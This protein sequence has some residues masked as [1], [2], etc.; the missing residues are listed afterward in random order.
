MFQVFRS[1]QKIKEL[2]MSPCDTAHLV[3]IGN[4]FRNINNKHVEKCFLLGHN[5]HLQALTTFGGTSNPNEMSAMDVLRREGR[6]E[7][8][9]VFKN[10][11]ERNWDNCLF[12]MKR[13]CIK[14]NDDSD[15]K[16][17]YSFVMD[18]G[19]IES[20][21]VYNILFKYEVCL[22]DAIEPEDDDNDFLVAIPIENKFDE[23]RKFYVRDI[24]HD[25]YHVRDVTLPTLK[26]VVETF[27]NI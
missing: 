10:H 13:R 15:D 6:E 19:D 18:I 12:A 7:H 9:D 16:L 20:I 14:K 4:T 23:N 24:Y 22:H 25:Q 5:R 21:D 2:L 3:L 11:I 8:H 1:R 26:T 17:M 27:R